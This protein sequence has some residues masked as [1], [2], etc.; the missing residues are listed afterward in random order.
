VLGGVMLLIA[1]TVLGEWHTFH[2]TARGL[3]AWM[4]LIVFGA[5]VG[6]ASFIYALK[7][8][9]V[10]TVSLYAYITPVLAVILGA[11]VMHE[12]FTPRMAV[13]IAIIFSGMLVVRRNADTSRS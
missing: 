2:P 1:G 3:L 8:M 9:P 5:L 4:Y 13:A 12:P 6:Y 11:V 10:S 7:Y